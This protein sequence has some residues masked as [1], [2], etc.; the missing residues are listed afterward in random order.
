M[1]IVILHFTAPY[2]FLIVIVNS[3]KDSN[4]SSA[5]VVRMVKV[6]CSYFDTID[7][8]SNPHFFLPFQISNQIRKAFIFNKNEGNNQK[9]VREGFIVPIRWHPFN[10]LN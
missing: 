1:Y 6:C 10:N 2:I 5:L 8:G 9:V 7:P 3:T 4:Q